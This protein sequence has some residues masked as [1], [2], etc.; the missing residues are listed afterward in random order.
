MA[1]KKRHRVGRGVSRKIRKKNALR[2]KQLQRL[3]DALSVPRPDTDATQA[4]VSRLHEE[5]RK[6]DQRQDEDF[7]RM[8]S[9]KPAR[10]RSRR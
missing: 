4:L 6:L 5:Y 3:R 9:T 10:A 7:R 8:M 1:A 2:A